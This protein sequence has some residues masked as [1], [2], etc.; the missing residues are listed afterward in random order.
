MQVDLYNSHKML[1][2]V[3]IFFLGGGQTTYI[4]SSDTHTHTRLTALFPGPPR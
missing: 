2:V 1:V 3:V 4:K